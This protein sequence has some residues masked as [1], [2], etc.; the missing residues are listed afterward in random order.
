MLGDDADKARLR[1]L[2]DEGVMALIGDST[3]AMVEGHTPSE[4]VA[5]EGLTQV[6]AEAEQMVAITCFASNV[7]RIE[8]IITAASANNR[9]VC[10]AGWA[11]LNRPL[12]RQ[13]RLGICVIFRILY[14]KGMSALS[15]VKIWW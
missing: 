8:S 7:A 11:S 1:A 15:R 14:P 9:S 12:Q 6:I 10:I 13:K 2:G 3:N 4:A 5:C